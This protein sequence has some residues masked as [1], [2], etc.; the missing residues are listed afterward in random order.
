MAFDVFNM[1][2]DGFRR[3][4]RGERMKKFYF[5]FGFGQQHENGYHVIEAKNSEEARREMFRKFGTKWSMQYDSAEEAGVEEFNLR[6]I[7]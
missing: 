5:T 1:P 2:A 6:E 4:L 3:N 7:K